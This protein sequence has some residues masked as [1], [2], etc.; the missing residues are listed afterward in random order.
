MWRERAIAAPALAAV[1]LLAGCVDAPRPF[2]PE[3]KPLPSQF[4]S[5]REWRTVIPV[6]P[7]AGLPAPLDRELAEAMAAALQQKSLPATTA[8]RDQ[9]Y[10]IYS[11]GG[12]VVA[13]PAGRAIVWEVRDSHGEL[14]GR[15]S[16]PLP[17]GDLA[18]DV[19][20]LRLLA[21]LE[22]K[23]AATMVAGIEGDAPI[24]RDG[25][26][27][28]A[29]ALASASPAPAGRSLVV[30]KI[31][32]APGA[33]GDLA[34]RQA[35]EY[36][37]RT[38]KVAVASERKPDSLLL[39]GNVENTPLASGSRHVKVTWTLERPNGQTI[40]QVSQENDVAPHLLEIAWG[41]IA[42]AVARNAAGGIA[43]LVAQA[44]PASP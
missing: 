6:T 36:A 41:E 2:Q 15:Q 40:G 3:V 35:I 19:A 17:P 27:R 26:P 9:D 29:I 16:Q 43:E 33:R 13:E 44:G 22:G 32:G 12:R 7:V 42:S 4:A 24:P 25:P 31:E 23:P 30:S 14:V 8:A 1:M 39:L 38:A 11:V 18:F 28:G 21:G 37:L 10:A 20:R 34:L 5:E